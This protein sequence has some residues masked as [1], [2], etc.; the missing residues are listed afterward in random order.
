MLVLAIE[1]YRLEHRKLPDTLD[2]VMNAYFD[3]WPLD[4]YSGREFRYFSNDSLVFGP[5]KYVAQE[6][7]KA[8][9]W[10]RP[11]GD[12]SA[13]DV[14]PVPDD[15]ETYSST[16]PDLWADPVDE[17]WIDESTGKEHVFSTFRYRRQ[18]TGDYVPTSS[19]WHYGFW[20]PIPEEQR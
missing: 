17:H 14:A 6:M 18:G 5:P 12:P 1:A 10:G 3:R 2:E 15:C 7:A 19:V 11:A 4:P 20:F 8:R 9:A 13:A 16:G